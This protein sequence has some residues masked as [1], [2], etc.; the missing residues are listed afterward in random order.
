MNK[1]YEEL[2][3]FYDMNTKEIIEVLNCY[4]DDLNNLQ[5]RLQKDYNGDEEFN[6]DEQ[7]RLALGM[8]LEMLEV[9]FEKELFGG[10]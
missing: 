5:Y 10:K 9:L 4:F 8:V 7:D 6:Q 2:K 1:Q 3:S